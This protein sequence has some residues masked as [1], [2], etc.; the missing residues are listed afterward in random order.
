MIT[1]GKLLKE[2]RVEK[3]Y[4]LKQLERETRIKKEFIVAIEK[5]MWDFLPEFPVVQGFVKN[6]AVS[7]GINE[8]KVSALLRRDYPPKALNINPKPDL[9]SKFIWTPKFTFVALALVVTLI[10]LG[11]LGFQYTNFIRSPELIIYEPKEEQEI[12]ERFL[13]VSGRTDPEA[14]I[15]VN[16]QPVLIEETGEF[17]TEIEVSGDTT[18]VV[19]EA[20]SRSGKVTVIRRGIIPLIDSGGG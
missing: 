7:L 18:E 16:N 10:A 3:K 1:I 2:K 13:K 9:V 19:F 15:R 12:S 11:Y 5:Q 14:T 8:K 6:I 4:S 20:R 17:T